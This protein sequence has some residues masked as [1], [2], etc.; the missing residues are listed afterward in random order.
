MKIFTNFV[1]RETKT[2]ITPNYKMLKIEQVNHNNFLFLVFLIFPFLSFAQ[3][4]DNMPSMKDWKSVLSLM[5]Y[6]PVIPVT[7]QGN[8]TNLMEDKLNRR[9]RPGTFSFSDSLGK[10][11][12]LPV[13]FETRGKTRLLR[14][15]IAPMGIYFDKKGLKK[16]K[17]KVYPKLKTVL[18]CFANEMAEDLL[19]REMLVYKLYGVVSDFDFKVQPIDIVG[20]D[21][22]T[23][24]TTHAFPA[25]FIESDKEFKRRLDMEEL[26][27]FNIQWEDLDPKQAQIT[28]F[29]QYMVSN[30]DW[31]IDHKHNLKFF[32]KNENTPLILVPYDFD[33]SGLVNVSYMPIAV[34][35]GQKNVR[36]RIFLGK[37]ARQ[38]DL[39]A[40]FK[41]FQAKK[42]ELLNCIDNFD[43][44]P[45]PSRKNI[46]KYIES[47][48]EDIADGVVD[49]I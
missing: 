6:Q 45:K 37:I 10:K 42:I 19:F 43:L 23:Q 1:Y 12:T 5:Q 48:Y 21:S 4:E 31:R 16:Q 49:T 24:D 8:I 20:L 34:H 14:C 36:Q 15:D 18:P 29:F 2:S 38:K 22:V 47:F 46:K 28:A 25:F 30:S 33:F 9:L 26:D 13:R 35:L 7:I 41:Y 27:Q 44:L 11:I 39:A 3:E 17:I 40:N 32:R